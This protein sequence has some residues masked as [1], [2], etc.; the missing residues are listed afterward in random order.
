MANDTIDGFFAF[1]K[2]VI[3]EKSVY[4]TDDVK[5]NR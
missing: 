2:D 1:F 5:V 3:N 4:R